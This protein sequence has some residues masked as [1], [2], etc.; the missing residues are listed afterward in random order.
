MNCT[1]NRKG[2]LFRLALGS[3]SSVVTLPRVLIPNIPGVR[4]LAGRPLAT[5]IH[6]GLLN[7]ALGS[8]KRLGLHPLS[9]LNP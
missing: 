1:L 4:H 5:P 2:V 3:S 9:R 8:N 7:Y 6:R